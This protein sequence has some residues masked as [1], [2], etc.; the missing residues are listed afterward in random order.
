MSDRPLFILAYSVHPQQF[1]VQFALKIEAI[2]AGGHRVELWVSHERRFFQD[3]L[4]LSAGL[5]D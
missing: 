1:L 3:A 2:P 5:F 4:D